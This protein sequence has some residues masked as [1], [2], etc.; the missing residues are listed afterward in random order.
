MTTVSVENGMGYDIFVTFYDR[1]IA[2]GVNTAAQIVQDPADPAHPWQNRSLAN[3]ARV[4]LTVQ[5]DGNQ[6][7]GLF[8]VFA[9]ADPTQPTVY[10]ADAVEQVYAGNLI[11]ISAFNSTINPPP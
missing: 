1:V 3:N 5:F 11:T 8:F 4:D 9:S 10:Y 7:C 2:P 6:Q